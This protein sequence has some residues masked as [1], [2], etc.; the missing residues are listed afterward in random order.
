[1]KKLPIPS[2]VSDMV[3]TFVSDFAREHV[4]E[5]V[6]DAAA[7]AI[8]VA[9]TAALLLYPHSSQAAL[10]LTQVSEVERNSTSSNLQ[11]SGITWAGGNTYYV[12]ED[13]VTNLIPVTINVNRA[14]G[15]VAKS[16]IVFGTPVKMAGAHDVEGCA[17]DPGSKTVW[18]SQETSAL[19]REYDPQTGTR[20]R[21]APVPAIQKQYNGNLSLESLTISGDGLTMWTCNEEALKVDGDL[22]S[23]SSGTVV[24]LTRFTR[25]SVRD[26]WTADGQWAYPVEPMGG[27]SARGEHGRSGVADLCALPD[28][29]LLAMERR[30]FNENGFFPDFQIRIYQVDFSNA[31]DVSSLSSLKDATYVA[32]TKNQLWT[33]KASS[34]TDTHW[35]QDMP[36]YEGM[37]LGPRLDDGSTSLLLLCDGGSYAY[38]GVMALKLSGLDVRT[39]NV[40]DAAGGASEPVGGPYRYVGGQTVTV[41]QVGATGPYSTKTRDHW[42]WYTTSGQEGT[43]GTASFVPGLDDTLT[44]NPNGY[45]AAL[46]LLGA[47]SFERLAPGTEAVELANW[48]GD[49]LVAAEDYSVPATPG[50][51]LADEDHTQV[52]VVDGESARDYSAAHGSGNRF[53]AMVRVTRASADSPVADADGQIALYFDEA[54]RATLQHRSADGSA[55]VR[56]PLSDR[57]FVNGDW[58]RVSVV[59]DYASDPSGAAWCQ[60]RLDGEPCRTAA[61]VRSPADKTSFGSWHRLI[62]SPAASKISSVV[63]K[64]TGAVDDLALYESASE[65]FERAGA[66]TTNGVPYNWLLDRD[67]PF[68]TALDLDGDDQDTRLEYAAGTDPWDAEDNFRLLDAGFNADGRFELRYTGSDAG[69]NPNLSVVTLEDLEDAADEDAWEIATGTKARDG[70]TNV[71]TQLPTYD[72]A[73]PSRFYKVRVTLP[74]D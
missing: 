2:F 20:L 60:I 12:V 3:P 7:D 71:W 8:P 33:S 35:T 13:T 59:L 51:P 49:G 17:W 63:F 72:A 73:S 19:I 26:G 54:G 69:T 48:T 66:T 21:D 29:S 45:D 39:V 34:S 10:A 68:D 43:G 74:E 50:W 31:T 38:V 22:A 64:G 57:V 56:T 47:D 42:L 46:P 18:A 5:C 67:L 25:A 16:D 23:T 61:G 40:A 28:G 1:M 9:T 30:C 55:R 15:A 58:V 53:D 36:N 6:I 27:S 41:E 44:W 65:V 70:S 4:P 52:L 62:V 32:V 14:T 24:R 37:C 11:S